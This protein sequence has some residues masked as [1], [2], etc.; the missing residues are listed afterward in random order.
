MLG[1]SLR[2]GWGVGWGES[3]KQT[4]AS[5]SV[6]ITSVN[7]WAE[8]SLSVP[9]CK[10][11]NLRLQSG[12]VSSESGRLKHPLLTAPHSQYTQNSLPVTLSGALLRPRCS[13]CLVSLIPQLFPH[14]IA[15][16]PLSCLSSY[17]FSVMMRGLRGGEKKKKKRKQQIFHAFNCT[18]F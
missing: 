5:A 10:V 3:E 14:P 15:P 2:R 6:M 9:L 1:R 17:I 8:G 4:S 7:I 16:V 18:D 11:G 12:G 13:F